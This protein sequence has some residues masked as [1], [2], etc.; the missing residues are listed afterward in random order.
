MWEYIPVKGVINLYQVKTSRTEEPANPSES[1]KEKIQKL[2]KE[3]LKRTEEH[4]LPV[5]RINAW[6][7]RMEVEI[8]PDLDTFIWFYRLDEDEFKDEFEIELGK[9]KAF[10]ERIQ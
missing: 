4:G 6:L 3:I 2:K 1:E 8:Y 5:S 9:A 10:I 7:V